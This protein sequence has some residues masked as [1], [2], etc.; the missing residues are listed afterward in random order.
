MRH[1]A[2]ETRWWKYI[3]NI[4]FWCWILTVSITGKISGGDT[5]SFAFSKVLLRRKEES[6]FPYLRIVSANGRTSLKPSKCQMISYCAGEIP[7]DG[8]LISF[9]G[10]SRSEALRYW[11]FLMSFLWR[12]IKPPSDTRCFC[13]SWRAAVIY[14]SVHIPA[15]SKRVP[16]LSTTDSDK[17]KETLFATVAPVLKQSFPEKLPSYLILDTERCVRPNRMEL[18]LLSLLWLFLLTTTTRRLPWKCAN[19]GQLAK[20]PP[21]WCSVIWNLQSY[22]KCSTT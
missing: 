5:C 13:P 22:E 9:S 3:L 12:R 10:Y 16:C 11:I 1:S 17:I 19:V 8:K 15:R 2:P 6:N 7:N 4:I 14:S 20:L 18:L 21:L